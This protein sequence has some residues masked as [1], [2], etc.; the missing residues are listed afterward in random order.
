MHVLSIINIFV[1]KV[2]HD[3]QDRIIKYYLT[4]MLYNKCLFLFKTVSKAETGD[5]RSLN[6]N[7]A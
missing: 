3:T 2:R 7:T 1:C 4:L 6:S 5:R